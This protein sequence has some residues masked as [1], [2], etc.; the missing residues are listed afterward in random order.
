MADVRG[1][2][3]SYWSSSSVEWIAEIRCYDTANLI[4]VGNE[5]A[6]IRFYED[7]SK[8]PPDADKASASGLPVLNFALSRYADVIAIL[9][10][11]DLVTA[12]QGAHSSAGVWVDGWGL[13]TGLG[14]IDDMDPTP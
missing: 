1:Y 8:M 11:E 9:R 12:G 14:S 5:N 7:P 10:D 4:E 6:I 3:I 2:R 13:S